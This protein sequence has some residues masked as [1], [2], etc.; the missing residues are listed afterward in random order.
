MDCGYSLEPPRR[1][2]LTCTHNLW[3]EQKIRKKNTAEK[4]KKK[5]KKTTVYRTDKF[6]EWMIHHREA[7]N[8]KPISGRLILSSKCLQKN[9]CFLVTDLYFSN[10]SSCIVMIKLSDVT[11]LNEHCLA[12]VKCAAT[13]KF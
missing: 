1:G 6:S 3:F 7:F 4:K 2:V 10:T 9:D 5:K 12:S 11:T 13:L 8:T